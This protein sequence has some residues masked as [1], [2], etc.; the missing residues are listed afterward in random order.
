MKVPLQPVFTAL[1][2]AFTSIAYADALSIV[3]ANPR[4]LEPVHVRIAP[5]STLLH[6]QGAQVRM[7]ATAIEVQYQAVIDTGPAPAFDVMLGR[8]PTGT[9]EVV[10][11]GSPD[12]VASTQFTVGAAPM[13]GTSGQASPAAHYTDLWWNSRESGWGLGIVQGPTNLIFATWFAYDTAGRPV[14]YT[15]QPGE[16]LGGRTYSGPVYKTS[17]PWLG[18]PFDPATVDAVAVGTGHLSFT[19]SQ[20][21]LFSYTVEGVA[22]VKEITR[23][24]VE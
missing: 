13:P 18:G 5:G 11:K 20:R 10:V 1:A 19:D 15:L 14:W 2:F 21:G 24:P 17:G 3:P 22:G 23:L 12:V 9:Y 6:I 8:F 16:W 4:Y 7:T